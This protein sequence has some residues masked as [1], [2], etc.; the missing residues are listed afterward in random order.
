MSQEAALKQRIAAEMIALRRY[1]FVLTRD[2]DAAEELVQETLLRALAATQTFRVG[3]DLR[4]WL[5]AVLRNAFIDDRRRSAVDSRVRKEVAHLSALLDAGSGPPSRMRE[6]LSAL[7]GL[8]D[9]QARAVEL[10]ALDELTY[11]QAACVLGVPLGTLMSRLARGREA[12]RRR[13]A[14]AQGDLV[15]LADHRAKR[16]RS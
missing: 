5:F 14:S 7:D 16:G 10:V 8:P 3:G 15:H 4:V 6:I 12:L 1:A 9:D 2:R 11:A 13:V